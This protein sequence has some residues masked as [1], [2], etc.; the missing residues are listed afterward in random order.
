MSTAHASYVRWVKEGRR[1]GPFVR[2]TFRSNAHH[3]P[4]TTDIDLER[5]CQDGSAV[6]SFRNREGVLLDGEWEFILPEKRR[7]E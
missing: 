5:V 1:R 2:T 7:E 6:V 4:P 3:I